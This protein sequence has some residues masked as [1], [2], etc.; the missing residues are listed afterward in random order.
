MSARKKAPESET[1]VALRAAYAAIEQCGHIEDALDVLR[2]MIN[3][4]EFDAERATGPLP[5]APKKRRRP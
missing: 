3:T 2:E 4:A 1:V 5:E